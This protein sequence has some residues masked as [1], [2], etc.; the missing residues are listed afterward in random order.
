MLMRPFNTLIALLTAVILFLGLSILWNA[1][2]SPPA[3]VPF[4]VSTPESRVSVSGAYF[5]S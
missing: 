1:S 5:L 4:S 2:D 3:L